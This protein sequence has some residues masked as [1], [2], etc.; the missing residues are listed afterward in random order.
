MTYQN[1]KGINFIMFKPTG[2]QYYQSLYQQNP[3]LTILF[4]LDGNFLSSNGV[5]ESYGYTLEE[6]QH[7]SFAP[8]IVPEYLEKT[9]ACFNQ[10]REGRSI[11]YDTAMYRKNGERIELNI[12]NIPIIV[13]D[14][15][16]A[17]YGIVKDTTE[18]IH[19]QKA[20]KEMESK[21]QRLAEEMLTG[22]F[23]IQNEQFMY[24]NRRLAEWIDYQDDELMMSNILDFVYPKDRSLVR[25]HF[26][27]LLKGEVS[28]TYLQHRAL[29]KDQTIIHLEI[30]A[31][32]II[33]KGQPA[34]IG[35]VINI[36]DRKKAEE[37]IEF[38]AYHDQVT[39]LPNQYHF[40][41]LL[42]SSLSDLKIDSLALF[43]I[44]LDKFKLIVNTLGYKAG[45][46]LL[47]AVSER[48]VNCMNQ[49]GRIARN[50]GDEFFISLPN[51]HREEASIVAEQIL[52]CFKNPFHLGPYELYITPSIGISLYP[53]D[54]EELGELLKKADSA[55]CQVKRSG[56]NQY[57]FYSCHNREHTYEHLK[58]EMDLWKALENKE[59]QLYY[60]PKL[61]LIS[62]KIKG[63]EALIR[64]KHSERGF[65]SPGEFIPLAEETGLIIRM[66]EW[67][68]RTACAQMKAWQEA[69]LPFIQTSVN[70]SVLQLYQP[71]LVELV[72]NVLE[73][74]D[75]D[76]QYLEFELTENMLI[77][78]EQTLRVLRELKALGVKISLD[79]FGTG[80]SSFHYLREAPID[81]IKIDQSFVRNCTL[82]ANDEVIVK[83]I[84][85][86][87]HQLKV[88]VV[89][90]GVE[91]KEQLIFLQR[92]LCNEAQGYLFC[93]PLP[94][95]E[96]VEKIEEIEQIIDQIGIP[97]E[98][99][100]QNR[101]EEALKMVRQELADTVRQQQGMIFKYK[102]KDGTFI[103][104]LC[105]GELLYRMGLM[106]EQIVNRKLNDF[107]SLDAAER[108]RSY[109]QRAWKGE[110]HVTYEGTINGI[111][112][113]ASLRPIRR[114][115]K[116]VEVIGSCVD[117]TEQK[118]AMEALRLSEFH[119][120][121]ITENMQDL[122]RVL[123]VNG[124]VK[125]ASPSYEKITGFS[126]K[127]VEGHSI[128]RIIHP[129]D[130][131]TFRRQFTQM[132]STK[133]PSQFEYRMSHAN[134]KWVDVESQG[135]PVL[136]EDG[137]IEHI[138]LAC[139]DISERKKMDEFI[140][141]T[142]KVSVAGQLAAGVAHEIRNPLTTVKGFL[143]LMENGVDISAYKDIMSAELESIER[144]VEEFLS[145]AK[146][147]VNQMASTDIN[148][149]LQNTVTLTHTQ[150]VLN[151]VKVVQE[152]ASELPPIECDEH[153]IEQAF[154]NVL[155]NSV[156][157]MPEGGIITIQVMQSDPNY[158]SFRFIDQGSGIPEE[159]L[160]SIGEPFYSTKEKGTGL[161]LMISHKIVQ[162]HKGVINIESILN[163]GTTVEI[164]LPIRQH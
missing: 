118:K 121:L 115:G 66:G 68:L 2:D 59:F 61:D 107:L 90:E 96:L 152:V 44:D 29:K 67:V 25:C 117:I 14:Q 50:I 39:G 163:Q 88:E 104:T 79:D 129:D 28:N 17:I 22:I 103:H 132:I 71:D 142:E 60:Q 145:L 5:I 87:A 51:V 41:K 72:R 128:F 65:I 69:G 151:N 108:K 42:E 82:D 143:Q 21:Y 102:E 130:R 83:T 99:T 26:N 52:N 1:K 85:A 91:L 146:P 10:A 16:V 56:R 89:A 162:E 158:M 8:Y 11:T 40:Y 119:Y 31:T 98:I 109:Y 111:W 49:Q 33:Y 24:V 131:S 161:G 137:E 147:C 110:D 48:L 94:P 63:V 133:L 148:G 122:V 134:G 62:G 76:P 159:R 81:R 23:I 55:M 123:D 30:H 43:M 12:K 93:R 92:L 9:L 125:Y 4:D 149:L 135:T 120:R 64:W 101:T 13:D 136:N 114:G 150:A 140:R 36:T 116:V 164:L 35:N 100:H 139:R 80:Y 19:A 6:V 78:S 58:L 95:E 37:T 157:A 86:M 126:P 105:D 38:M 153:R 141:K 97:H 3:D 54:G 155:R 124:K 45:D 84:I 144:I 112:Y 20:L 47:K 53:T 138:V 34:I 154:V 73:E 15:V 77:D 57:K 160:K 7:Q 18:L 127:Q 74:T 32:K 27:A 156:E 113:L 75:L 46:Q 106:P 70:L